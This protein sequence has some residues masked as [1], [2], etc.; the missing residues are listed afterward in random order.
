MNLVHIL[1]IERKIHIFLIYKVIYYNCLLN[2]IVVS[3]ISMNIDFEQNEAMPLLHL[4]M[5]ET[6]D[7]FSWHP[8]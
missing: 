1:N 6:N 8:L 4:G 2:M 3:K 5:V 7:I